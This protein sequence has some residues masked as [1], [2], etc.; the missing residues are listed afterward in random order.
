[1]RWM[2]QGCKNSGSLA[3][4]KQVV[5]SMSRAGG[6]T[7]AVPA[8]GPLC[9]RRPAAVRGLCSLRRRYGDDAFCCP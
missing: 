8:A 1:M 7:D 4:N 3:I 2:E 6:A 5:L 9:R